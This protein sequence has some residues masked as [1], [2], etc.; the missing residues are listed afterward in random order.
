MIARVASASF[1]LLAFAVVATTG[2]LARNSFDVT[3]SRSILA[4]VLF[5]VV[6]LVLGASAQAVVNEH[7]RDRESQIR[8]QY[9]VDRTETDS[10]ADTI[11]STMGERKANMG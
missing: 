10:G 8:K 5:S 6:G 3:L 9:E 2:L 1:G 7:A 11:E 4:L